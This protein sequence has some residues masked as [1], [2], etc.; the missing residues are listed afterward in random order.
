LNIEIK[1]PVF[2]SKK[3]DLAVENG[4][5]TIT[6]EEIRTPDL[7]IRNPLLYPAELRAL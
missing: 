6:P 3:A 4:V 1:N 2:Y 7:R 5:S